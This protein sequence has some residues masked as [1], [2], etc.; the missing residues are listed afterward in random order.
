MDYDDDDQVLLDWEQYAGMKRV[1]CC[2]LDC[3]RLFTSLPCARY[4]PPG[5]WYQLTR[6][7]KKLF[8]WVCGGMLAALLIILAIIALPGSSK[9]AASDAANDAANKLSNATS[10]AVL[11]QYNSCQWDE[12]RLPSQVLPTAYDLSLNVQ[13]EEPFIVTGKVQIQLNVSEATPCVVLHASRMNISAV[14][15][16][17]KNIAGRTH[18]HPSA[19]VT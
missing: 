19:L 7:Q 15:L 5:W 1:R 17:G 14:S 16:L 10:A 11:S 12:W 9:A 18:T 8:W 2:G 6:R 3:T 13:L 4:L